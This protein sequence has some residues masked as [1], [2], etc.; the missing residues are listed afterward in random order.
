MNKRKS[1][2][3]YILIA[4]AF[5][6]IGSFST[7]AI[8]AYGDTDIGVAFA[9]EPE[10]SATPENNAPVDYYNPVVAI[11]EECSPSVVG[12]I[13]NE[14]VYD[15]SSRGIQKARVGGGSG[16]I[17]SEDG[18][19]ITNN[20]VVEGASSVLVV[21]PGGE[22]K[23]AEIVG[24]DQ[25]SD[26]A[27]LKV[28]AQGLPAAKLGDSDATKVG[29]MVVAIGTPLSSHLS[30]SVTVG[31]VSA[32]NRDHFTEEGEGY[33][34]TDAAINPGNSG[35]GLFNIKGELIGMPSMKFSANAG[36]LMNGGASIEG[37]AFAIPVNQIKEITDQLRDE[38]RVERPETP[39]MG[40]YIGDVAESDF[41]PAG[42]LIQGVMEDSPALEADL[43]QWDIITKVGDK[44]VEDSAA[45]HKALGEC[46]FGDTVD[47]EVYRNK[48]PMTIPL[49]F[50]DMDEVSEDMGEFPETLFEDN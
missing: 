35:G 23:D 19:I 2:L 38:G 28:D 45:L 41:G 26:I 30:G 5:L 6:L 11:A 27:L 4:V 16:V 39:R 24:L 10:A 46:A 25:I 12:V 36:M 18:Y 48:K 15:Y 42:V 40:I 29:E 47:I 34:Q 50:F 37:L 17:I 1:G 8:N 14:Y 31:Y 22:E 3:G 33:I 9:G 49:T 7:F 21:L 32:V 20:H 13:I 44:R 43:R